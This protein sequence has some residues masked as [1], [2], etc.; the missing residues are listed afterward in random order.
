MFLC[1]YLF[2]DFETAESAHAAV[3]NLD[4]HKMSKAHQLSVNKFTD[5]EKYTKMNDNYVEPV[6]EEF[7]PKEHIKSWLA[8]EQ[9]RDQFVMYRGDDVS[10][11]W[12]RKSEDP[13][14]VHTRQ[15]IKERGIHSNT[16]HLTLYY[17]SNFDRT[18]RK[19]MSNG[20]LWVVTWRHSISKVLFCGVVHPGARLFD[21]SILE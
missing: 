12:N 15:V 16:S 21:S 14:H 10:I 8:D 4:G 19:P 2:I 13:E 20:H 6:I 11:F 9:A 17:H 5:V 18:G 1:S 3:K 7:A